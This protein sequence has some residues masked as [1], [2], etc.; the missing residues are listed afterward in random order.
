ML[1][2]RSTKI[3][4]PA[5][6]LIAGMAAIVP[7]GNFVGA[8]K[9]PLPADYED[10]DLTFEGSRLKGFALGSEGLIADW[11]WM[12]ALQYIGD[13]LI[14]QPSEQVNIDDLRGLNPRL[15]YP[16]LQ[17]ATDVDPH[18]IAAYRYGAV[19]LPAIE[20]EHAIAIAK[21]GIANNPDDWRLY[22]HLGYIYWKLKLYEDA[23]AA[24]ETGS[25][26]SDAPAFMRLMAASMRT[27][28]GSRSVS[29]VM[30]RQLLDGAD[31]PMVK[32]TAERRLA[33]IDSL[34]ERD[35][36]DTAL[37]E[38]RD[39]TGQCAS[40]LSEIMPMLLSVKLPEANEFNLDAAG[41]LIDPT[42][43]RYQL[44]RENCRSILDKEN[45]GLPID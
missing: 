20:P 18:F 30:F 38:L 1:A 5:L 42:G 6:I 44:D 26:I 27:E 7:I 35:A 9:P 33:Q 10:S 32:L 31:D 24:Y 14:K 29:R 12:R 45:T 41:F 21:K 25:Q 4:L 19:V 2:S 37:S 13:K 3:I 11:Y 23:A 43:A 17:N 34:D 8:S 16:M 15:L 39:R 28:G 36:I 22:Q 40:S